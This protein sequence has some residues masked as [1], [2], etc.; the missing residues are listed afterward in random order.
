MVKHLRSFFDWSYTSWFLAV[1]IGSG[2]TLVFYKYFGLADLSFVMAGVWSITFWNLHQFL[3]RKRDALNERKVRKNPKLLRKKRVHY[4]TWRWGV[5]GLLVLFIAACVMGVNA[6][7]ER[8]ELESLQGWL[9]PANQV[10]Q[11]FCSGPFTPKN[12]LTV[13][14]GKFEVY[15]SAFPYTVL[16]ISGQRAITLNRD[17]QGRIAVSVEVLDKDNKVALMNVAFIET[18]ECLSVS[19]LPDGPSWASDSLCG[20]PHTISSV[21]PGV[22]WCWRCG[23]SRKRYGA[24]SDAT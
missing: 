14:L 17:E 18:M 13:H 7:Q 23:A 5:T 2:L 15:A 21:A 24:S 3:L 9:I 16:R 19:K 6:V 10:S 1:F 22:M 12:A 11:D 4:I 20:G 8:Y